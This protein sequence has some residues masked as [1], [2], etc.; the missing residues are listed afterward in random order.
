MD[1]TKKPKQAIAKYL[2][3]ILNRISLIA[4]AIT[5]TVLIVG[6]FEP[7][8][9]NSPN[10]ELEIQELTNCYALGTD[11]IGRGNIL[12][13]KTIYRK[14]FTPNAVIT[15]VFPSGASETRIGT[16]AWADFVYSVFQGNGYL[17]TQHLIG[18]V[19]ISVQ[20]NQAKMSSYLHA[21]HKRS[22]TSIDVANGTYEDEVV[23]VNGDW[24]IK[25]RVLTLNN[26]LNLSS[27]V[28]SS[29]QL[30]IPSLSNSQ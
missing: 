24:K 17:L 27:P 8:F 14:C 15:A 5:F 25:R 9:A 20:G 30:R 1:K 16:D 18:T 6:R 19:S 7:A 11:A 13:G 12:E 2:S 23:R 21:T 3:L 10:T 4:L 28:T 22:E 26:F 29:A